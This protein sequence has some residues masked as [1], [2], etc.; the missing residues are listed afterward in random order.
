MLTNRADW[1]IQKEGTFSDP[2]NADLSH[3]LNV[4]YI[5]FDGPF[6]GGN[7]HNLAASGIHAVTKTLTINNVQTTKER[8][9]KIQNGEPIIM[10]KEVQG[11][12]K[13]LW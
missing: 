9:Q 1:D 8:H 4:S 13:E 12:E 5:D 11:D 3:S 2:N 6:S 7:E 10:P